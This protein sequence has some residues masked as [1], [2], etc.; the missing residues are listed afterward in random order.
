MVKSVTRPPNALNIDAIEGLPAAPPT[1]SRGAS[2]RI[3]R[4][5][6]WPG[7]VVAATAVFEPTMPRRG[8]ERPRRLARWSA[9]WS[10][11]RATSYVRYDRISELK[12][13]LTGGLGNRETRLSSLFLGLGDNFLKKL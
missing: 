12:I 7:L 11:Q 2:E 13:R 10:D 9:R 8:C 5:T 4:R 1:P 3:C 6:W